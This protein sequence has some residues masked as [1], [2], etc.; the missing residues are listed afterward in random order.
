MTMGIWEHKWALQIEETENNYFR[1]TQNWGE[2]WHW[3]LHADSTRKE[4]KDGVMLHAHGPVQPSQVTQSDSNSQLQAWPGRAPTCPRL[5][6]ELSRSKN[7]YP[8]KHFLERSNHIARLILRHTEL[9]AP[10]NSQLTL[11]LRMVNKLLQA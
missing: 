2:T 8:E 10:E 4:S 9:K 3:V 1:A 7:N 6:H 5:N 11:A